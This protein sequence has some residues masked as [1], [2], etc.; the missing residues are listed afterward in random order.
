MSPL[1]H[2]AGYLKIWLLTNFGMPGPPV[3]IVMPLQRVK[4]P[5]LLKDK[6][7]R[8]AQRATRNQPYPLLVSSYRAHLI[9]ITHIELIEPN[10]I[11][12]T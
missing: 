10:E 2:T 11:V 5:F 12:I 1:G 7:M 6:F 8:R 4:F 3:K 9:T